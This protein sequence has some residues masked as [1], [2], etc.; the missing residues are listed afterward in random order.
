MTQA[1]SLSFYWNIAFSYTVLA[2]PVTFSTVA[3][4]ELCSGLVLE[5]VLVTQGCSSCC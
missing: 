3:G 2:L 5:T 4:M 1:E